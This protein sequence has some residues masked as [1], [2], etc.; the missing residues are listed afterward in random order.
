[1][2]DIIIE[3]PYV[4]VPPYRGT[5]WSSWIQYFNLHGYYLKKYEGVEGYECRH[6]ERLKASLAAGHGILLTPNHPRTADPLVLGWLAWESRS[7]FYAMASWHLFHKSAMMSW[8]MRRV[9]A[10]SV[11][12]EGVDRQAISTAIEILETAE[13]PLVIFPEGTTS[14]A[15]DRLQSLLDGVAFVARAAA[16]KRARGDHPGKVVVHPIGIKYLF[17]GDL[18]KTVTPVLEEIEHRLTWHP[19]EGSLLQRIG[20]VGLGLI[21]L[22][23]LE[24]LGQTQQG[25]L[26][27]RL[28]N[29]IEALLNPLEKEWMAGVQCGAVVPRVKA[30]RMKLLPDMLAGKIAADERKRRWKQ[31]ADLYLAQQLAFYPPDYLSQPTVTRI[32]ETVERFEEDLTDHA[33]VHG[34]LRAVIEVD[35]AIEV[36]PDRD[37]SAAVDPLMAT[38]ESRLQTMLDRLSTE[39]P[40]WPSR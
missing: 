10:F 31:L 1:M 27:Q 40:Q 39:S 12:R 19:Q 11:Y 8:A 30:I 9:G 3:K 25:T 23:E 26:A 36:S 38:L 22:K 17:H 18:Q 5:A 16:K 14:R 20:R 37:R 29:L 33:R 4:F 13:R 35:E 24:C 7:H 2:Q 34:R 15:N 21:S 32:L 6:V 28:V